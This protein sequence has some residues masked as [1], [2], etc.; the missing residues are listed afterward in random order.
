MEKEKVLNILRNSSNL[1]LSLIKEFLSDKDKDIKHEAWN[2][3]IL[4]VK[5][6]EFLLELLSFHDTGTRYR[7][8]NS[9]PEFIISGRLTLEEVISR[10]RYFLE[11]LKDDNKVV[12]ALSWYVTLKPLLEM[13]I[14]KME[15][16]LS[17]SPFLCEL[18]NSEFHDVVLDTMD[19]FRIT[20]KF[21]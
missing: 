17:Y 11:M 2:Y 9:V 15:E 4:N 7:A 3:V 13:K 6:K 8:W 18:I 19:E 10:K 16:I 14:V 5:D 21:I 12:R 1:P 20:C